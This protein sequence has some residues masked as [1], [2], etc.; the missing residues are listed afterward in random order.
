MIVDGSLIVLEP[1]LKYMGLEPGDE[2]EVTITVPEPIAQVESDNPLEAIIG[3][4]KGG[5][6][7][8]AENHDHYLYGAPKRYL[9]PEEL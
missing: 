1:I 6:V 2:V 3:M 7:D 9:P 8:G 4:C 5:P